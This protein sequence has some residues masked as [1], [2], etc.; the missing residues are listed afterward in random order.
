MN[1]RNLNYNN[2]KKMIYTITNSETDK[3]IKIEANSMEEASLKA[4]E[5]MGFVIEEKLGRASCR[6]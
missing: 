3:T 1:G 5:D 4:L 2:T 6:E